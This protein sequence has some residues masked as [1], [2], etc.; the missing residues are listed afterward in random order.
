MI[1]LPIK[2]PIPRWALILIATFPAVLSIGIFA[3]IARFSMA[4]D[5]SR[6]PFREVETR[7][8]T[9]EVSVREEARRCLPEIEEHRWMVA[10]A[11]RPELELGRFPLEAA[12]IERGFPWVAISEDDRVVV[13]VT[14]VE[15]G[16]L[17]FREPGPDA[18]T[19]RSS[20]EP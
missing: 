11:G 13:T 18:G 12:Q 20:D 10:R 19:S 9:A 14:N 6:C 3:F 16:E 5:E 8:V 17:V 2:V 4:H 15:R 7:A 1:E